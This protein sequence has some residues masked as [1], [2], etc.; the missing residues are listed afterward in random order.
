VKKPEPVKACL[1]DIEGVLV[2]DKSYEP[3][4]GA[5][6]WFEALAAAGLPFRLVSNNTTATPE[7]LVDRLAALGFPVTPAHL[8][9]AL[10]AGRRWL[11]QRER[12]RLLWLGHPRLAGWWDEA[13]FTLVEEAPCDAVVLGVNPELGPADLERAL[14]AV[15][16]DG[17][18]IVCLHRNRFWLDETGRRRPG[19]GVWAAALAELGGRGDVVTIGKPAEPIYHEALKS[20]GVSA[21]E[22]LF[23]SDDPEADLVTASRLGMRTAFVLSGKH[24]DH[25]VLARLDQDDWPDLVCASLADI[26]VGDPAPDGPTAPRD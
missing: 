23:I 1:I 4:A 8:V 24:R 22:S 5:V 21:R 7:E 3:V 6:A 17:V 9:G 2:R 16:D 13:G 18:D 11:A 25:G 15:L 19:P 26:D 12:R 10:G 14:S 20:I